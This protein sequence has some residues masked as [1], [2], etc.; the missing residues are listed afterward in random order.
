M[1][2][3]TWRPNAETVA[4]QELIGADFWAEAAL[5]RHEGYSSVFITARDNSINQ[6]DGVGT[7]WTAPQLKWSAPV[8][9]LSLGCDASGDETLSLVVRGLDLNLHER[10]AILTVSEGL[11]SNWARVFNMGV[12]GATT[13]KGAI[14]VKGADGS[15]EDYMAPEDDFSFTGTFQIPSNRVGLLKSAL[16]TSS[17]QGTQVRTYMGA[18]FSGTPPKKFTELAQGTNDLVVPLRLSSNV[19]IDFLAESTN[20]RNRHTSVFTQIILIDP[21]KVPV[22]EDLGGIKAPQ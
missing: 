2:N 4:K 16:C 7:V 10:V 13:N 20:G 15:Y 19:V 11:D 18:H 22:G 1:S 12:I 3:Y 6:R 9:P 14:W 17:K 21:E 8:L 5:G